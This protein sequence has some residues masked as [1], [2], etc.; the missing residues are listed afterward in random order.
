MLFIQGVRWKDMPFGIMNFGRPTSGFGM[1]LPYIYLYWISLVI[2]MYPLCA[3]YGKYK[4]ANRQ[5][6]WLKYL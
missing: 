2:C 3:W 4:A 1:E 6:K 5:I